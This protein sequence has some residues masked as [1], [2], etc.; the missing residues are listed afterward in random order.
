MVGCRGS[1]LDGGDGGRGLVSGGRKLD[2]G[3]VVLEALVVVV[4][5]A[6][7]VVEASVVVVVE[8]FT[9]VVAVVQI[10]RDKFTIRG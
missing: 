7:A 4:V 3:V 2:T 8:T 6:Q 1:V 10:T 5:E 9:V